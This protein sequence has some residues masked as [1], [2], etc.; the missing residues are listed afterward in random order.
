MK[1]GPI[2]CFG[3][4]TSYFVGVGYY[5]TS[6]DVTQSEDLCDLLICDRIKS[7]LTEGCLKY[8]LS[9]EASVC[10]LVCFFVC[11]LAYLVK[12]NFTKFSVHAD[13]GRGP[14]TVLAA[15]RYM[16]RTSGFLD[17]VTFSHNGPYS[18]SCAFL[19]GDR[20]THLCNA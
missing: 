12:P 20:F 6:R 18:A 19:S 3:I 11:S 7:S 14:V 4:Q 13:C 2:S 10:L 5:L 1:R 8:I 15:L 17:D 9:I 16:L